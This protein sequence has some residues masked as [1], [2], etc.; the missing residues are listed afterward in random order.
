MLTKFIGVAYDL[1][2]ELFTDLATHNYSIPN[3]TRVYITNDNRQLRK[4]K[5]ID[6]S[7]IYYEANLSA[8]NIISFIKDLLLKMSL[9]TEDF[10][11]SL[12]EI[13]FDINDEDTWLEGVIPVAKLFYNLIENLVTTSNISSDEIE[14]LR[15]K[16]YTK[17]LF[18]LTDYPAIANNRSDNMGNSTQKRY[19]AKALNFEG[20]DFY[21]STQFFDSDR[22][23]ISEWYKEHLE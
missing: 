23:A 8:N 13:P 3:A 18:Q 20:V 7:G 4:A 17:S 22:D 10:S 15:T 2:T 5:Q 19:I 9:D 21:I 6:N 12:S 16:E 14:K 11:F 1:D